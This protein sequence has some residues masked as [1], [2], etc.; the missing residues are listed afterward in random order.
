MSCEPKSRVTGMQEMLGLIVAM[1]LDSQSCE[2]PGGH[3]AVE[4]QWRSRR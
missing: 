3:E 1:G 4:G 2:G